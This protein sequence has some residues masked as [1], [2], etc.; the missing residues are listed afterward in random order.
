[1]TIKTVGGRGVEVRE[2]ER[3]MLSAREKVDRTKGQNFVVKER[4]CIISRCNLFSVSNG[5]PR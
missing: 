1:M 4:E 2:G 3:T 5:G